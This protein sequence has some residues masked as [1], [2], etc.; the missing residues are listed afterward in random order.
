[1]CLTPGSTST[2]RLNQPWTTGRRPP[3]SSQWTQPVAT[4]GR[5][6]SLAKRSMS[7]TSVGIDDLVGEA[8]GQSGDRETRVGAR[9]AGHDRAVGDVQA[10]MAED[11]AVAVDDALVAVAA[12]RGAAERVHGD[13]PPQE[14][15]GIVGEAAAEHA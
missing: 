12:H 7:S 15:Q 9:R 4:A 3:S 13:D 1:M 5:S 8:I 2:K 14:P 11:V 6:G 10:R